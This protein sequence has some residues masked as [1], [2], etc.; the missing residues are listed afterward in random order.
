MV[1]ECAREHGG[2]AVGAPSVA[3]RG[4]GE[5]RFITGLEASGAWWLGFMAVHGGGAGVGLPLS[6]KFSTQST[7]CRRWA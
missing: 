1:A 4:M 6:T 2:V 3:T 5:G 7:R